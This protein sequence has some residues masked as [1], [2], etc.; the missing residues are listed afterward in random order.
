MHSDQSSTVRRLD[1]ELREVPEGDLTDDFVFRS[2]RYLK[3]YGI[4]EII[5]GLVWSLSEKTDLFYNKNLS[6]YGPLN[7][8]L[9]AID[10][11]RGRDHEV[12]CYNTV[13]Q[14]YQLEPYTSFNQ[15]TED[16]ELQKKLEYFYGSVDKID[17]L[18]G[19]L[20]EKPYANGYDMG[21]LLSVMF[22][23]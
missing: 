20:A 18:V 9:A 2:G 19:A 7:L 23:E 15:I 13:R 16:V 22:A 14:S 17:T 12:S 11:F 1:Y 5:M 3:K 6:Q 10:I 8:D 4:V 21:E